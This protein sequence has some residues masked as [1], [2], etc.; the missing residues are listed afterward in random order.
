VHRRRSAWSKLTGPEST[1]TSL[2][3][4]DWGPAESAVPAEGHPLA[5]AVCAGLAGAEGVA[6]AGGRIDALVLC[7]GLILRTA[8]PLLTQFGV[9]QVRRL[10]GESSLRLMHVVFAP[11]ARVPILLGLVKLWNASYSPLLV[12]YSETWD[13]EAGVYRPAEAACERSGPSGIR[14]LADAAAA[15]RARP[16]TKPPGRGLALDL[17][18]FLEPGARRHLAFAY[19]APEPGVDAAT[20]V[21][22]WRGEVA[23]ELP[24]TVAGWLEQLGSPARP[25]EA[26]RAAV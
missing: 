10:V 11:R 24:R 14:A 4:A 17:R 12:D 25:I 26:Y 19:A 3:E 20:L 18:L 8:E 23:R 15:P 16:P 13:V 2:L 22:A 1:L 9:A 7:E 6:F 5:N 21:R